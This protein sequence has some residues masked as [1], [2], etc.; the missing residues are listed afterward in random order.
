MLKQTIKEAAHN[1]T[2]NIKKARKG[3]KDEHTHKAVLKAFNDLAYH[4]NSF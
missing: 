4:L 2:A 3:K 1:I